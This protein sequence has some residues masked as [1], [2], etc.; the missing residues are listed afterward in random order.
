MDGNG[1][2]LTNQKGILPIY[3]IT[4]TFIAASIFAAKINLEERISNWIDKSL[5]PDAD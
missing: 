1:N 2:F 5:V 3:S 4:K